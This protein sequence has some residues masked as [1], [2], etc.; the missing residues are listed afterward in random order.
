V[1]INRGLVFWGMALI[2]AGAMA[3]AIQSGIVDGASARQ[4][5]RFWPVVLIIIGLAVIAARTPFALVV[6]LAA[7]LVVGGL[8][9][10]LV[11]GFPEGV[12]VG[13]GGEPERSVADSGTFGESADV[14]LDLDCGEL[15][16]S[17]ASGSDWS[18]AAR[19]AGDREPQISSNDGS[20]RV[21][22]EGGNAFFA[23]ARQ[24]WDVVLPTDVNLGLNVTANA[25]STTLALDDASLSDLSIDA[26]AGSI[27]MGLPG[28]SVAGFSVDANAGSVKIT[29]DDG[30]TLAGSVSMNAGSLELCVP[31]DVGLAI[32]ISDTNITF[33]HNLDESGLSRSGDTWRT[34]S[35][36]AAITL[37]VSGN[38][39]SFTLNP[40]GGCS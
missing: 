36:D 16:V 37:D 6:T 38:A 21:R 9:G 24:N 22:A 30:T 40:D 7:G 10:T 25:A 11:G 4:L 27:E 17:T 31:D 26:N 35:G 3:L 39:A 28:A 15:A 2:T 8:A 13:C 29:A 14:T 1:H 18:V 32:T 19:Y 12:N 5:W 23:D 34:G 33:S 20:L